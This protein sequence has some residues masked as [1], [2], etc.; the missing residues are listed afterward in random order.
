MT[1]VNDPLSLVNIFQGTNS[2]FEFSTGNT[3]PLMV[4]PWGMT[5]WSLQT[6]AGNWFYHHEDRKCRGIRATHQPSPWIG[7]YGHFNLMP[8]AGPVLA[9]AEARTSSYRWDHSQTGPG[10]G[11]LRLLRYG[12]DVDLAVSSRC[13]AMR[14]RYDEGAGEP[15]LMLSFF[16]GLC[17]I[18]I[19]PVNRVLRGWTRANSGGVADNYACYVVMRFDRPITECGAGDDM[20]IKRDRQHYQGDQGQAYVRFDPAHGNVLNVVVATSFISMDQAE[21][22]LRNEVAGFDSDHLRREADEQWQ[23]LFGRMRIDADVTVAQTF[24]NALYRAS[25]FPR[26]FYEYD[27]RDKPIHYSPYDGQIHEGV[28]Y[29]DCGF[30]DLHRTLYP[31][32]SLFDPQRLGEM[33]QGWVNAYHEGGWLPKWSSPGYRPAMVGSHSD[34]VLA[35]AIV[36]D[37]PGF[38]RQSAYQ[39]ILKNAT[40]DG[41]PRG[42]YGRLGLQDYDRMGYVPVDQVEHAVSRT[43]DFAMSDYAVSQAAHALGDETEAMRLRKRSRNYRNVYDADSGFMRGRYSDGRWMTPFDPCDWGGPYCECG[44]W[45][46][47]WAVPHDIEGLAELLGGRKAAVDRLLTMLTMEPRFNIGSY[48]YEIHEMTEMALADFGTYAHSNQP[49][50]HVL[51]LFAHLGEP[52]HTRYWVHRVATEL[53]HPDRLLGDE[54]NG[55]MSAWYLFAALGFYPINPAQPA[56]TLGLPLVRRAELESTDGTILTII[57]E[58]DSRR[59]IESCTVTVDGQ[60]HE[61]P[62]VSHGTLT[63]GASLEFTA[64]KFATDQKASIVEQSDPAVGVGQSNG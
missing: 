50:H 59:L 52:Q 27:L 33:I 24:Y 3:L 29:A 16:A 44:A 25:L 60:L 63:R 18:E 10:G 8:F 56:Y 54:D 38:D 34:V 37:I 31:W 4:R 58:S 9:E 42:Y 39:A 6:R 28:L 45:Q 55:E 43:L 23:A 21:L 5:A 64:D 53:Y 1:F 12:I 2:T 36:K 47:L 20:A 13:M 15:G 30:W 49:V 51:Y 14:L 7:D 26:E 41:E 19:D 35:E 40:T 48:A 46:C 22:N 61:H 11:R 17:D 32:L 62:I 57:G